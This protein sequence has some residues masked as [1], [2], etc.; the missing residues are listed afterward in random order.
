MRTILFCALAL[1]FMMAAGCRTPEPET[2]TLPL[3]ISMQELEKKMLQAR[4]P[5][6]VFAK[7]STYVQKIMVTLNGRKFLMESKFAAPDKFRINTLIDNRMV[8][9]LILNGNA[10][11]LIDFKNKKVTPITGTRLEQM[12]IF[13]AFGNPEAS[14]RKFFS[15]VDLTLC[16]IGEN[17]Y[18]LMHCISRFDD[19]KPLDIYV[20][21][22]NFLIKRMHTSF[23]SGDGRNTFS[24]YDATVEK[25]MLSEGVLMP[26][27]VRTVN[28]GNEQLTEVIYS[29]LNAKIAPEE[30]LP[31]VFAREK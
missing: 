24:D 18:Y 8:S 23:L 9:S 29:K 6:N 4:D 26:E 20:G 17:E 2:V 11:W 10:A 21:K 27:I 30:F 22:D 19:Q 14:Y 28:A 1:V 5:D 13:Y 7:A 25:Y 15:Q 3:D 16:R 31:P 12:K